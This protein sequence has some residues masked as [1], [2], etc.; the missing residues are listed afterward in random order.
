KEGVIRYKNDKA[1]WGALDMTGKPLIPAEYDLIGIFE[2]GKAKIKKGNN[3]GLVDNKGKIV[4]PI[5]I[6]CDDMQSFQNGIAR[7]SKGRYIEKTGIGDVIRYKYHGIV[8]ENGEILLPPVYSDLGD[9]EKIWQ[10]KSGITQIRIDD[11][12]GYVDYKGQ[13]ILHPRYQKILYFDSVFLHSK[14]W[15]QVIL[16]GKVGYI[17]HRGEEVIPPIY[18][19]LEGVEKAYRDST[20]FI[21]ACLSKRFGV[22][23]HRSKEIIPFEYD[24]I[25]NYN[26]EG[27][28]IAQKNGKWGLINLKNHPVMD[29]I[30][31]GMR[32]VAGSGKKLVEVYKENPVTYYVSPTGEIQSSV[33]TFSEKKENFQILKKGEMVALAKNNKPLTKYEY[34]KIGEFSEAL[35]YALTKDLRYGYLNEQGEMVIAPAYT[36]AQSFS[37]GLAAVKAKG[38]WGFIDKTGNLVI[39][40]QFNEVMPFTEDLAVVEKTKI[41][42]KKGEVIG[43]LAREGTIIGQFYAGRAVAQSIEG[44]YHVRKDGMPAYGSLYDE[45]TPFAQEGGM[46]SIAF[47]KKGELWELKRLRNYT[48]E[49]TLTFTRANKNKY[50]KE[51]PD[52]DRKIKTPFGEV[53]QDKGWRLIQNGTWKMIA[54]DGTLINEAVFS[55]VKPLGNG[56]EVTLNK[57]YGIARTDGTWL[58]EPICEVTQ[59]IGEKIVRLEQAGNIL[60]L[61]TNG[62]WIIDK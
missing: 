1:K 27:M 7:I 41:I 26:E 12:V 24:A 21:L 45:V 11:K 37:N 14:G 60:Y 39:K 32:F 3:F 19:S 31:D 51:N 43:E 34:L 50:E 10:K 13:T 56:F 58:I 52:D 57:R 8:K 38:K 33:P 17:N 15:S 36:D 44:M 5:Q 6:D 47:V 40:H 29:F 4:L 16:N 28:F 55:A 22:I 20:Q 25:A 2:N 35:A 62:K 23:N 42:D 48:E 9:F 54:R 59:N 46:A 61:T 30:Y 49:I 53:I 18:C